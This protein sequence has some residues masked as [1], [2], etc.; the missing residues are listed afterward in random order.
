[1]E[2]QKLRLQRTSSDTV[3]TFQTVVIYFRCDAFASSANF[4]EFYRRKPVFLQFKAYP[5]EMLAKCAQNP[6]LCCISH[7]A[8]A[9]GDLPAALI[10]IGEDIVVAVVC[11]SGA[12]IP[13][14][15]VAG[16]G[17]ILGGGALQGL[18]TIVPVPS[19]NKVV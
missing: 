2:T 13:G 5:V 10:V 4:P 9:F 19:L 17:T 11:I 1:M 3:A 6:D 15:F 16:A 7:V 8:L 18:I 12:R 14:C